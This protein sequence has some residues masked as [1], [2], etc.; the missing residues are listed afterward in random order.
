MCYIIINKIKYTKT[1]Y[2]KDIRIIT[3]NNEEKSLTLYNIKYKI[4]YNV[5]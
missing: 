1:L 4:R 2:I 5:I 3:K